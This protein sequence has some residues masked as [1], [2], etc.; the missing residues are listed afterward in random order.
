MTRS[1]ISRVLTIRELRG[2]SAISASE[3]RRGRLE[4]RAIRRH[5]LRIA[6]S[7]VVKTELTIGLLRRQRRKRH[8]N[9]LSSRNVSTIVVLTLLIIIVDILMLEVTLNLL[10]DDN[11]IRKLKAYSTNTK[12]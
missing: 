8:T 10:V 5:A 11:I 7:R 9:L 2:R 1:V 12:L 3:G 6:A 4:S